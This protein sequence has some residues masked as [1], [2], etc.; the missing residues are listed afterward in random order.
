MLRTSGVFFIMVTLALSLMFYAWAFRNP[1]FNGADGMGGVPRLD[2]AAIGVNMNRPGEFAA[3]M[4][5]VCA[6]DLARA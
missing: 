1:T 6:P 4:M 5:L 2:L 3:V